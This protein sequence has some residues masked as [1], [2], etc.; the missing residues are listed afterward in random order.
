M[1][2]KEMTAFNRLPH[3]SHPDIRINIISILSWED[4]VLLDLLHHN[5]LVSLKKDSWTSPPNILDQNG[6]REGC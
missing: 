4:R 5:R 1:Y 6:V 2:F 3:T